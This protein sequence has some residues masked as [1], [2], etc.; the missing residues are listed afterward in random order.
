MPDTDRLD[1]YKTAQEALASTLVQ[2]WQA[3]E[4][5]QYKFTREDGSR[6]AAGLNLPECLSYAL[7]LAAKRLGFNRSL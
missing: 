7:G 4:A 3:C 2:V 6:V 5:E 1:A